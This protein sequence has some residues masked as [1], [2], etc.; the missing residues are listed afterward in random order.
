[1][2][3]GP[4][5]TVGKVSALLGIEG[6]TEADVQ[7]AEVRVNGEACRLV[8]KA[9]L[10]NPKP[11][12]PVFRFAI[13]RTLLNRGYNLIEFVAKRNCQIVWAEIAVDV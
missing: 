10:K 1:M 2:A 5:P 8:G 13:P 9:E 6:L 7:T 3:T 11:E 4:I 12:S